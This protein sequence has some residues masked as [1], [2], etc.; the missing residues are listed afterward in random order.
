MVLALPLAHK[1][2]RKQTRNQESKA[3]AATATP[4]AQ[5]YQDSHARPPTDNNHKLP[6]P[7][8][9]VTP[10]VAGLSHA[11]LWAGRQRGVTK[12]KIKSLDGRIE[13]VQVEGR[14]LMGLQPQAGLASLVHNSTRR[15]PLGGA[16]HSRHEPP[17]PR[18][19]KTGGCACGWRSPR[20][21][22]QSATCCAVSGSGPVL[23]AIAATV[24]HTRR[25][26][27]GH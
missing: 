22:H 14:L 13:S 25:W 20:R 27:T 17:K 5:R 23:S 4:M 18:I 1:H 19:I 11:T 2:K 15:R 16:V 21:R 12:N 6:L 10:T 8:S 7:L 3:A 24:L 9:S 26:P